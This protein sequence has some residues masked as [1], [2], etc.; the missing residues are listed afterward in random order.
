MLK[1]KVPYT[2]CYMYMTD[3]VEGEA[4]FSLGY[5]LPSLINQVPSAIGKAVIMDWSFLKATKPSQVLDISK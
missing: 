1:L 3:C 4:Y 2:G 5:L